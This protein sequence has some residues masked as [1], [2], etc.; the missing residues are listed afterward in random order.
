MRSRFLKSGNRPDKRKG[1]YPCPRAFEEKEERKT[2]GGLKKRT[3][4]SSY[5]GNLTCSAKRN[6]VPAGATA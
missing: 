4:S 2:G 6:G 1:K 5:L 3:I